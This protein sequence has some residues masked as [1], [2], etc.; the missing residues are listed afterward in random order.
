L[1][2]IRLHISLVLAETSCTNQNTFHNIS[3]KT[4]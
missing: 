3:D 1:L 4:V 2:S